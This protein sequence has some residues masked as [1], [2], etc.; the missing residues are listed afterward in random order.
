MGDRGSGWWPEEPPPGGQGRGKGDDGDGDGEGG[1]PSPRRPRGLESRDRPKVASRYSLFVGLAFILIVLIAVYNAV[2]TDE[3]GLL[4]AD[5]AD[6]RGQPIPEFAAPDVLAGLG[7][8]VDANIAQDDCETSRNPCPADQVRLPA[9]RIETEGAIR[10]CDLCDKPLAISFWF[11][12]GGNCLPTQDA[13]DRV[14]EDRG[15]E[16]NFLSVN[17]LDDIDEVVRLVRER[18]WSMPV[19]H[20]ADGAVSNLFGV[21]VCPTVVFA[22]PGGILHSAE[23][24][25]GNYS[26]AEIDD[27]VDE[28]LAASAARAQKPE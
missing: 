6:R 1:R 5:P 24:T 7:G 15:A 23:I 20:D 16:L 4:G 19:A 9:C 11:T 3:G 17:V 28:L 22:Y 13:F 18:G 26:A 12:R 27:L 8:E 14:R 25:P 21:G 10:V 2:Q